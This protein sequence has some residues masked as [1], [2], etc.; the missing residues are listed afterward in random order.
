MSI[1]IALLITAAVA[2]WFSPMSALRLQSLNFSKTSVIHL[3]LLDFLKTH[4]KSV[5]HRQREAQSVIDSLA[6]LDMELQSGQSP[7]SALVRAAVVPPVW[8]AALSAVGMQGDVAQALL[9]DANRHPELRQ[10]AACWMVAADSGS[11]MSAAVHRLIHSLRE[12]EELRNT[13]AAELAGPRA[14]AK[15][16]SGL[17][18]IGLL[19]GIAMGADPIGWLLGNPLGIACLICGLMLSTLGLLWSRRLVRSVE[20]L[21]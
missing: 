7:Q 20:R 1:V 14:T 13:L 3:D 5:P 19:M 4:R 15:V 12:N 18:V 10:L 8:P 16:L 9:I 21:L 17:P 2:T 6:A 11:G